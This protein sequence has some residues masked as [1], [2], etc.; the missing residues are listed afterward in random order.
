MKQQ[1]IIKLSELSCQIDLKKQSHSTSRPY[2]RG[3]TTGGCREKSGQAVPAV[4]LESKA[5]PVLFN[6]N[7]TRGPGASSP[8]SL[9]LD[10][11]WLLI[12]MLY[13]F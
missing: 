2:S 7:P 4:S 1:V 10:L 11:F 9:A 8:V 6:L 13:T 12:L 3:N 5:H